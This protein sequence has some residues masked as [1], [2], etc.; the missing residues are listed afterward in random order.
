MKPLASRILPPSAAGLLALALLASGCAYSRQW[1]QAA[2]QA[3]PANDITGRWEGSWSSD[4]TG[5]HGR[6]RCLVVPVTTNSYRF[7]YHAQY[8][9]WGCLPLSGSYSVTQAVERANGVV[10]MRGASDLPK[11]YGGRFEYEGTATPTNFHSTYRSKS[12]H[13]NFRLTRPGH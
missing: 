1:K 6:L 8:K 3:V 10:R 2:S 4:A 9:I 13:G 11:M 5:H 7:D 12:D